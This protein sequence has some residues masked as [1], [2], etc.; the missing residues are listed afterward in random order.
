LATSLNLL[1]NLE[2]KL[3]VRNLTASLL[4][5]AQSPQFAPTAQVPAEQF[6]SLFSP[7]PKT[8]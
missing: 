4:R 6:L 8:E 2:R 3:D 7:R 5:Y 1:P